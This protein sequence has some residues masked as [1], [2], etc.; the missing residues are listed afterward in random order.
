MCSLFDVGIP[1]DA[2]AEQL[3]HGVWNRWVQTEPVLGSLARLDDRI[4]RHEP[5]RDQMIGGLLRLAAR[6]GN[7]DDLAGVTV[8]HLMKP[9]MYHL[10]GIYRMNGNADDVRGAVVGAMWESIKNFPTERNRRAYAACLVGDA[11]LR[12]LR[13]LTPLKHAH[14]NFRL[15]G[16]DHGDALD[17]LNREHLLVDDAGIDLVDFLSWAQQSHIVSDA[18]LDL[19]NDLLL[20]GHAVEEQNTPWNVRGSSSDAARRWLA[21]RD[22]TSARTIRRRTDKV[23]HTL[24]AAADEYLR[25]VA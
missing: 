14:D 13:Y 22:G 1:A 21:E 2:L 5:E 3:Q 15:I 25:Q 20:A 6:T 18:D 8:C 11:R 19:I 17:A 12:T 9:A 10:V 4:W 23:L 24:R 16:I 7:D